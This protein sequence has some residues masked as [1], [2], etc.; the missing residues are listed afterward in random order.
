MPHAALTATIA[1]ARRAVEA[2]TDGQ[3]LGAFLASRDA[4]SFAELVARF[5]PMVFAVCRK[6]TGNHHDAE[7]AFQAAFVVLARRAATVSPREAVGNWLYGVAVRV[8]REARAVSARR[9]AREVPTSPL[10][11]VARADREPDDLGR[12]LHE[13][14]AELPEKLR[15]LL[16]LCD[17]RGE[18]QVEVADRLGLPAGTVYSRLA[19]G[20][21]RL[22]DRLRKRGVA[23]SAAGLAAAMAG[24]GRAAVP[25]VLRAR[26]VAAG[27]SP[28]STPAAVAAL[29]DGVFRTMLIQKLILPALAAVLVAGLAAVAAPTE[30]RPNLAPA[31]RV[32][33]ALAPAFADEKPRP[34]AK[35]GPGRLLVW[36]ATKHV[37]LTPDGKEDGTLPVHPDKKIVREHHLSPDGKWVAFIA[38]E[39]PP[40]DDD[41]HQRYQ[42]FVRTTDGKDDGR[43]VAVNATSLCWTADGKALVATEYTPLA[44][45]KAGGA[46]HWKIDPATGEKTQLELPKHS[47]VQAAMPDGKGYLV[48]LVDFEAKKLHLAVADGK[49]ATKLCEVRNEGPAPRVSP[50]GTKVLFQDVDPDDKA[51]K[52]LRHLPRLFVYDR[53]AKARTRLAEVPENAYLLGHCWSPDG[54]KVAYAWKQYRPGVPLAFNTENMN[55]PK[56]QTV[57]ESHLVVCDA[58]GENPKTLLSAKAQTAPSITIAGVDWR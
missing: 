52:E 36:N 16:V 50:D 19:A 31:P 21:K 22:A 14:L 44:D 54:S 27:L 17:L 4:D 49:D 48:L 34:A 56:L 38:Q 10:P 6:L 29:S 39:D 30:P 43:T 23:L 42:V 26:A 9:R 51:E 5:G 58:T 8:A 35:P 46:T 7:D 18:A 1:R 32:S 41:G 55:D 40:T 2:D 13:E 25:P 11:D 53:K 33:L 47:Q 15:T 37:F 3:L 45:L 28:E 20:R 12:V 24:A 57:T